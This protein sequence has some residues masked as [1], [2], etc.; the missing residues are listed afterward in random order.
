MA[1]GPAWRGGRGRK[2]DGRC[3]DGDRVPTE[4]TVPGLQGPGLILQPPPVEGQGPGEREDIDSQD[5]GGVHRLAVLPVG[6]RGGSRQGVEEVPGGFRRA[7]AAGF[8]PGFGPADVVFPGG[9]LDGDFLEA[10]EEAL[11]GG[12]GI[13][14]GG[15]GH[16]LLVK[17]SNE[18]FKENFP[19]AGSLRA[20][21]CGAVSR[22]GAG[23][24]CFGRVGNAFG[25]TK[26]GVLC[27][28]E[29]RALS[30]AGI[31]RAHGPEAG[32]FVRLK[33]GFGRC[34]VGNTCDPGK[35]AV[36]L[37]EDGGGDMGGTPALLE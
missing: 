8:G 32:R 14:R 18:H 2:L 33:V 24:G 6:D 3:L 21:I 35:G 17:S 22:R 20:G 15:S 5:A 12:D 19:S 31:R 9:R 23:A 28:P 34:R 10:L 29:S 25:R 13:R 1:G 37:R 26:R 7:V 16:G 4:A 11:A 27:F 36:R 30:W